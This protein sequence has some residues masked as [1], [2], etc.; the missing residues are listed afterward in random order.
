MNFN[1]LFRLLLL[2]AGITHGV[3]ALA[4]VKV[5][6]TVPELA[7]AAA[8]IGGGAVEVHALLRGNENPHYVDAVP[9]FTRLVAE[10][11]IV[12]VVG[13]DLEVGYMPA[14]LSRSG[15]AKVQP[16]GPGYC[17]ASKSVPVLEKATSAVDRS[18]ALKHLQPAPRRSLQHCRELTQL[19][20]A[21]TQR[22]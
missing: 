2:L 16:G 13:L 11:D 21:N 1:K 20:R 7:W 19:T 17:D 10:A 5:V 15:N 18:L 4:K 14:V 3:V 9:E 12:C 22:D 6:A 8:E